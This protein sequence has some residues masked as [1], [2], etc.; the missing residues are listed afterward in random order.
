[1]NTKVIAGLAAHQSA[2]FHVSRANHAIT[3]GELVSYL[4]DQ[5]LGCALD[6]EIESLAQHRPAASVFWNRVCLAVVQIQSDAH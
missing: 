2:S 6:H 5:A 1:M 3:A 4:G